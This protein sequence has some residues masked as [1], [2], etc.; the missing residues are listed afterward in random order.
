MFIKLKNKTQILFWKTAARLMPRSVSQIWVFPSWTHWWAILV[1]LLK[2]QA[3]GA[4][5]MHLARLSWSVPR[6]SYGFVAILTGVE[7]EIVSILNCPAFQLHL[8]CCLLNGPMTRYK[9]YAN[10][11]LIGGGEG[12]RMAGSGKEMKY[13]I[14]KDSL[15]KLFV[16]QQGSCES[17]VSLQ[18]WSADI[19]QILYLP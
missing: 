2:N 7:M 12:S 1:P 18:R 5:N 16:C 13:S 17:P 4:W 10:G 14:S 9:S 3:F 8:C 11:S 6:V 19:C 15:S